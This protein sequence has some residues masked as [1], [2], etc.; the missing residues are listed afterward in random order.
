LTRTSHPVALVLG[1]HQAARQA[2]CDRIEASFG[3]VQLCQ[4]STIRD[5]LA[6]LDALNI[7]V[8]L[9][10][11]ES[12]GISGLT[13]TRAILERAPNV[14]VVVMSAFSEPECRLA[15]SRAGAMAFVSK[16]AINSDLIHVLEE[17]IGAESTPS[18]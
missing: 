14:S 3:N 18:A 6:L 15:A 8:V 1:S 2:L 13:G 7:D 17:L 11:G 16:R 4:A 12:S 5:A 9:I 10:D